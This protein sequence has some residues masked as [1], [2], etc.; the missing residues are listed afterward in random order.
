[1]IK[2]RL[3]RRRSPNPYSGWWLEING[4]VPPETFQLAPAIENNV[5]LQRML[6]AASTELVIDFSTLKEFDSRGLQL[7]LMLYKQFSP[8]NIQIVLRN[9][10]PYLRRVLRIMQ[11]DRVFKVELD[12]NSEK[13]GVGGQYV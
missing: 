11:F 1:M 3:E 10:N 4:A 5:I 12:E 2:A 8:Q 13:D 9:P 7:L 6:E